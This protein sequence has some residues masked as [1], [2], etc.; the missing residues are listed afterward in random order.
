MALT[1]KLNVAVVGLGKMG[2]S[3]FAI[4]H[5][6]P[7][8]NI[9][10]IC[11]QSAILS[12]IFGRYIK[13]SNISDYDKLI[14]TEGLQAIIIATPT[15]LHAEMIGSAIDKGLHI[16]CEK[17]MT[18]SSVES[19]ALAA[20]AHAKGLVCQVGYHNRF[21]GTFGEV[22]RLIAAGAIGR[23]RH[24]KAES[25]GPVVLKEA[26]ATW[27]SSAAEGGGCLY[28]YAAHPINLMNWY[29][30]K[31][32]ECIGANLAQQYSQGVD[33]A[34]YADLRFANGVSGQVSVN[35]SDDSVRKMTTQLTVWGDGGKISVDRQELR[36]FTNGKAAAPQGYNAGWTIRNITELTPNVGFYLRGEEYSAQIESFMANIAARKLDGVNGF[37]SAAETDFTLEMIRARANAEPPALAAQAAAPLRSRGMLARVL[38]R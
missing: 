13:V 34:V 6:H 8:I 21:V 26:A 32:V 38:G 17:P 22:A 28:D 1:S 27:R 9:T 7:E 25:Y 18:L 2:L 19:A 20:R 24:V 10:A 36:L 5:A 11:E 37:D 35:W 29:V 30:G 31:P 4:A 23:V 12:Q 14:A 16:F 33:D 3:H 15:R